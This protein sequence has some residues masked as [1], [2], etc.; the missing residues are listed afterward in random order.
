MPESRNV[1]ILGASARAAA[2]SARRAGF[3]VSAID[4]F[5]DDD[6]AACADAIRCDDYPR[7]LM[8][9]SREAPSGPWMYTGGLENHP[10]IVSA[11]SANRP[12]WGNDAKVL[13]EVRN[14]TA[15][16][17]ALSAAGLPAVE[18]H[19][20]MHE[21]PRDG[22]WLAKP[23]AGCGG[24]RVHVFDDDSSLMRGDNAIRPA[25]RAKLWFFQRRVAGV[26]ASA[27]FV[28]AAGHTVLLGTSEQLVGQPWS[29]A[30]P[31][32]YAGSLGPLVVNDAPLPESILDE[33]AQTGSVLAE[34]FRLTGL[35]GI[36]G[37]V[38]EK[39][40][41]PVEVNPRYT[42]SCEVIERLTGINAV[43]T[44]VAACERAALPNANDETPPRRAAGKLI[45]F[46][47]RDCVYGETASA[48]VRQ[49]NAD[50]ALPRVADIPAVGSKFIAGQ[51]VV[52][53]LAEGVDVREVREQLINQASELR[54]R[55]S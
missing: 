18:A 13:R 36:D 19:H 38:D 50:A 6:L 40:F 20:D 11:I 42:A 30:G 25:F 26:S 15:L 9:L 16:F 29:G 5:A 44:Q 53:V 41:W 48:C 12:L 21:V 4:L 2:Q 31:F 1:L 37:I 24:L 52:T 54:S 46:A 3:A 39:R 32:Q 51:P 14:P 23:V 7:N 28:A 27:V 8:A 33:V 10:S 35:F 22:N 17:E 49:R 43:A 55:L 34:R 45:V 47:T